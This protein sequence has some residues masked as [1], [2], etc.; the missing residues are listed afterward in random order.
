M[1]A[2][3][4][5]DW[6][7]FRRYN[8]R[9]RRITYDERNSA[10]SVVPMLAEN[11][12]RDFIL[13]F[14]EELTWRVKTSTGLAHCEMFL[15]PSLRAFQLE[16]T[17][18]VP[19]LNSFL[20]MVANHTRLT[21]FSFSSPT[22]L[23]DSFPDLFQQ[24]DMLEMVVLVAPGALSPGIGRWLASLTKLTHLQLDLSG[25]SMMAVE[26]F[27]DELF[28]RS[29]YSTP[30]SMASSDSEDELDF[31]EIRKSALR[32]T[33]D[34]PPRKIYPQLRKLQL[35]GEVSNIAVFLKHIT[36]P[37]THMEFVIE[38]PPDRADWQD[39]CL[40]ICE[41]FRETL[42]SLRIL[43]TSL[44]RFTD[45]IRATP[46]GEPASNRL[47]LDHLTSLP[48]LLRL[49]IDL[50]ESVVFT[51]A[52]LASLAQASPKLESLRLC[53]QAKFS[54]T[55]GPPQI[56]LEDL[57]I[58]LRA[59]RNLHT[60]SAVFNA[61]P[62]SE[63][64]LKTPQVSSNSLLRLQV[65]HSWIS[66]PLQ[67]AISVSHLAPRLETLKW[68]QEKT[69]TGYVETNAKHWQ[70]L[71]EFLP[72]LQ[73]VR[74]VER[75]FTRIISPVVP[76]PKKVKKANKC[77]GH[78]VVHVDRS[79]DAQPFT[80]NTYVQAA[81]Q[82]MNRA[83]EAIPMTFSVPVDATPVVSCASIDATTTVQDQ[84]IDATDIP[85][86]EQPPLTPVPAAPRK[87]R[88]LIR[89]TQAYALFSF[90]YRIFVLYPFEWP[91][92]VLHHTTDQFRRWSQGLQQQR[93]RSLSEANKGRLQN[94]RAS[95]GSTHATSA[96]DE[97]ALGSLQVG[98]DRPRL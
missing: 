11:K 32:L 30:S 19:Q 59:C 38:D 56:S 40:L 41:R 45:L 58:L 53:P 85:T 6:K 93:K 97:I 84:G 92:R 89:I 4:Q 36:S 9:V 62:I 77:V 66:D 35:T 44:S 94:G 96:G 90:F 73:K 33:G 82:A 72:H 75:T 22:T 50:P 39:L 49:E 1:K 67:V 14:L 29:G 42:S 5:N 63:D 31:S 46:R 87:D 78:T 95:N 37:L 76:P 2:P 52:D 26:G 81:P 98:H 3:G 20:Q 18:R 83:V 43:A 88:A 55:V 23:P 69:R 10:A 86:P 71:A 15:N 7:T 79:V 91:S 16:I 34:L 74:L 47:G 51:S 24:Q 27:F 64:F 17:E 60:V 28:S 13:P 12:P 80:V 54:T 68:F 70:N 57:A 65:G 21:T 25:R 61:N 8:E 48:N